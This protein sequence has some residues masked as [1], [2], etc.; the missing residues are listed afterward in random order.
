MRTAL[1]LATLLFA[2]SADAR[3]HSGTRSSSPSRSSTL[4]SQTPP[5]LIFTAASTSRARAQSSSS[6]YA[7]SKTTSASSTRKPTT[8]TSAVRTTT[9][10]SQTTT[11][12]KRDSHSVWQNCVGLL[13]GVQHRFVKRCSLR[14]F[15]Q[16]RNNLAQ[17]K[18]LCRDFLGV[19]TVTRTACN[20]PTNAAS[21]STRI[22]VV[23]S[24]SVQTVEQ[25]FTVTQVDTIVSDRT[26]V[27]TVPSVS[28]ATE[29]SFVDT[30]VLVKRH[31]SGY[32]VPHC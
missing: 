17:V 25:D 5:R 27:K 7:R 26:I 29:T 8:S 19:Q 22:V 10:K 14:T 23:D 3:P 13:A 2:S 16:L 20:A 32:V 30:T 4:R 6:S 24:V 12:A 11:S 28:V 9:S 18:N 31:R 21:V 15:K 1:W